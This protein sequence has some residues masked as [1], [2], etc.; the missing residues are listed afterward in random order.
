METSL[1]GHGSRAEELAVGVG[2]ELVQFFPSEM[3][4]VEIYAPTQTKKCFT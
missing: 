4:S 3:A 2:I 1:G